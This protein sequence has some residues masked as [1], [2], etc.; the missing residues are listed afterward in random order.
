V[1]EA[2][3]EKRADLRCTGYCRGCSER[4]VAPYGEICTGDKVLLRAN[5]RG[6]DICGDDNEAQTK[7]GR[8]R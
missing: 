4:D 6:N 2:F 5:P 8:E 1:L 3:E 7:E